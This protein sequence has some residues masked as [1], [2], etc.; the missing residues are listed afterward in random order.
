MGVIIGVIITGII[1]TYLYFE[2]EKTNRENQRKSVKISIIYSDG[3]CNKKFPIYVK[4]NNNSKKIVNKI[5]WNIGAYKPGYSNNV[6]NYSY[7]S[8]YDTPY[9]SDK[10]LKPNQQFAA[11]YKVPKLSGKFSP[12]KLNW[13]AVR[14][15]INFKIN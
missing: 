10:I 3:I 9:S 14:K 11:C 4:I 13:S 12:K 2:A 5:S 1:A 6:V 8:E 7:S 15:N